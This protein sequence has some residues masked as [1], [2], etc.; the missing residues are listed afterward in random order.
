MLTKWDAHAFPLLSFFF[1]A[2]VLLDKTTEYPGERAI[3]AHH[4]ERVHVRQ[5]T[6]TAESYAPRR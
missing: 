1:L 6:C 5:V 2:L 3:P 4:K